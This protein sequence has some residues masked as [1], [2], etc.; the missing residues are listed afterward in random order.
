MCELPL[1]DNH[2]SENGNE[3]RIE[4]GYAY[5]CSRLLYKLS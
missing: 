1:K 4:P 5:S 3:V 2:I